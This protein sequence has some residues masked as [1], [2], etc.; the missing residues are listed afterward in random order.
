MVGECE[1]CYH[2]KFCL[3]ALASVTK[4]LNMKSMEHEIVERNVQTFL[5]SFILFQV[6]GGANLKFSNPVSRSSAVQCTMG[7][8]VSKGGVAKKG[9]LIQN[10]PDPHLDELLIL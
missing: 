1:N 2:F 4:Q 3:A 10:T 6:V 8:G 7:H 5:K 9:I